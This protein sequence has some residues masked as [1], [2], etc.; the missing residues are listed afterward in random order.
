MEP[1]DE[2]AL[3]LR[4]F[5]VER[6]DAALT[7]LVARKIN[8]VYSAALRQVGGNSHLAAEVTQSVFVGL[9]QNAGS[10]RDATTTAGWLYQSTVFESKKLWRSQTRWRS[11]QHKG[12]AMQELNR[13]DTS[14]QDWEDIRP[15]IGEALMGLGTALP[16][17]FQQLP[18]NPR[19]VAAGSR[20]SYGTKDR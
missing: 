3:L 12:H 18:S 8:L 14:N 6:S 19:L 2:D 11:R 9:A 13:T 20:T 17:S 10:L 7:A 16:P 1:P 4:R 5:A 15:L